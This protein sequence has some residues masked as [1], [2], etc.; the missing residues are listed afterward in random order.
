MAELK[1]PRIGFGTWQLKGETCTKSVIKAIDIGFRHIDTA[2]AYGNESEVGA[3]LAEATIDRKDL[4]IATKVW[5][6]KL[7][8]KSVK[9]STYK[10]LEKLQLDHVDLLY[11]HWP[12]PFFY[13]AN[14]T[15][16][17]FSELVDEGKIKH[18]GVSNF[19]VKLLEE[20]TAACDKPIAAN[21]VEH[22]PLLK[23]KTL[24][25]YQAKKDIY[26][27]AYSPLARGKIKNYPEISQVAS[28]HKVSEFQVSLAWIMEHGAVPIPKATSESHIKDCHDALNITLDAEDLEI[29]ESI[30]TEK[31]CVNPPF[32]RPKWDKP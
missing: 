4:I 18:V 23:Q 12:M 19:N 29:I 14:K 11:V 32:V 10:S 6:H 20:A 31:R 8:P 9:K 25:E 2:Q 7:R 13:K 24:R 16:A 21:Q 1:L 15:L 3:A 22:H 28:K 30:Q 17:A 26:L 5:I 27:V